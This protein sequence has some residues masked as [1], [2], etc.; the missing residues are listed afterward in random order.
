MV[1]GRTQILLVTLFTAGLYCSTTACQRLHFLCTC[2]DLNVEPGCVYAGWA[3]EHHDA[4]AQQLVAAHAAAHLD[5]R[6]PGSQR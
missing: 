4:G 5:S 3:C 1:H 2:A 6:L